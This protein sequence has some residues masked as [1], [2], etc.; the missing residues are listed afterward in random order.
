MK[1][2]QKWKRGSC[3]L[4]LIIGF[5]GCSTVSPELYSSSKTTAP[6]SSKAQAESSATIK[7]GTP[8]TIDIKAKGLPT[9]TINSRHVHYFPDGNI[10]VS[11]DGK[12]NTA[13]IF[14]AEN[15]SYLTTGK[16]LESSGNA[17]P[18][19]GDE[20]ATGLFGSEATDIGDR[21]KPQN[22]DNSGSWLMSVFRTDPGTFTLNPNSEHMIGF[23]HGEDHWFT[24]AAGERKGESYYHTPTAWMAIGHTTSADNG[25]TWKKNGMIVGMPDKKP[26]YPNSVLHPSK[27][28]FG[29]IGNHS[30]ILDDR[31]NPDQPFWV[32]FFPMINEDG[33]GVGHGITAVRSNDPNGAFGSWY[34]YYDGEFSVLQH[35]NIGK[36]SALPGLDGAYSSNFNPYALSN[37]SVH[38]NYQFNRWVLVATTWDSQRIMISFSRDKSILSGWSRPAILYE[39]PPTRKVRYASIL[40]VDKNS[41]LSN[42]SIVK[43]AHLYWAEFDESFMREAMAVPIF[44]RGQ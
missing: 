3:Y 8:F 23:Y 41:H 12:N 13:Q 40:G 32:M 19:L 2:I 15:V 4:L 18:V 31:T 42:T 14:W 21:S 26:L 30:A 28:P 5:A 27:G 38:W 11:W 10:S 44:F 36:H 1:F 9:E 16:T 43:D 34:S 29:G 22:F 35:E 39:S 33:I 37:P 20:P 25:K 24:D 17:Y 7:L 6:I